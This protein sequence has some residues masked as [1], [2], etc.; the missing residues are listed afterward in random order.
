MNRTSPSETTL[1]ICV[2][3][4]FTLWNAPLSFAE[5]IRQRWP[6]MSVVHL[7]DYDGLPGA[8]SNADILIG[9]SLRPDQFAM[10]KKLKWIHA[11]AA[12][13][14]QLMF[15]ELRR[16]DV[17]VTNARGIHAVPM[18]EHCLGLMI[19]LARRFPDAMRAQSNC[20][21]AQ[22]EIWNAPVR[23]RELAGA[24][25]LLVGLGAVGRH[26]AR[27]AK[28]A[29][30]RVSAVTRTGS[31]D[32]SLAEKIVTPSQLLEILPTA[33][34]VV[35]AAPETPDTRRMFATPQFACMKRTAWFINIARGVLVD[36]AALVDAASRGAIAGA[37][38]DVAEHEPLPAGSPL[39]KLG[40]VFITPHTSAVSESLWARQTELV[41]QNLERWFAGRE[42][43]NRVNLERGY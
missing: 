4:R 13:V 18:A 22:Q 35:L 7:P 3:H 21:W 30:M 26:V 31:G 38:L 25:L 12:G 23:P 36:E 1:V 42:L 16:S 19:A 15:P 27:L 9:F 17:V 40:N 6:Q 34:F 29:G 8:L 43:L 33:D 24:M 37:A 14:G 11:T 28:A 41:I 20:H 10:A 39:W 2:C 32:L 5:S